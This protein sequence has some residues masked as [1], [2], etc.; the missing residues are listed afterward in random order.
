MASTA[1]VN[2]RAELQGDGENAGDWGSK[3]NT[4]FTIFDRVSSGYG[5]IALVDGVNT[6]TVSSYTLGDWHY[7]VWNLTGA[8]T[9][10]TSLEVPN[11]GKSWM[12]VDSTTGG[13]AVTVLV[14]GQTGVVVPSGG[15]AVLYHDGT[16]VATLLDSTSF[17]AA[18]ADLTAIAALAK[19]DGNI[20]VGD[21]ATWVAESGATARTSLGLAIGTDVQ[22]YA[23]NL[24]AV[25]AL[26]SAADK[27]PYFTGSGTAGVADL[28]A[29][30]RTLLDD[31]DA[32]TARATLGVGLGTG[33]V[34]GPGSAVDNTW[35]RYNSTTGKLIQAGAWAED[36]G[37]DVTAGGD[38]DM[39]TYDVNNSGNLLEQGLHTISMPA[40][41]MTTRTTN[42]AEAHS[43]E[44]A[45]Y[46]K[47]LVGFDF[48]AATEEAVQF[49]VP[50]PKSWNLGTVTA[51]LYWK[52]PS[53]TTNFDVVWGVSAVAV[54]N[55][56]ALDADF[57]T[58]IT[59][60]DTGGTTDDLYITAA[61]SAITIAGTPAAGDL[62]TFQ[63]ARVAANGSD[64]LAVDATLVAV[65]ILLTLNAATD[66]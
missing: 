40:G 1:A 20:I 50:M 12:V 54:G 64:T 49:D 39:Q 48:D 18:D 31:A 15:W 29:F 58:E 37:G 61:T 25:A 9:T 23:A 32:A 6:V 35:A 66:A 45:T 53:T 60:T 21:G 59:V 30:A 11:Y 62:V 13:Q 5:A 16:D 27:L 43:E 26:V 19:T 46:D 56:D 55:D 34:V 22:A 57:G 52:H 38:I 51:I 33:D 42:G 10:T 44:L 24:A 47:M 14:S 63:V 36:D 4:V 2:T 7:K 17:Q 3:A 65:K 8:L 28:T 41:G